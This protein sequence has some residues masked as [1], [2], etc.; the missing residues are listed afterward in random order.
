VITSR[1][2]VILY[3]YKNVA[4]SLIVRFR[5]R[6]ENVRCDVFSA[7]RA[8]LKITKPAVA[9]LNEARITG[10]PPSPEAAAAV[11]ALEAQIP[12]LV[13]TSYSQLAGSAPSNSNFTFTDQDCPET[14]QGEEYQESAGCT[15]ATSRASRGPSGL[16]LSLLAEH[17][18][19]D[20]H[21]LIVSTRV[22]KN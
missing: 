10:L 19:W 18:E 13:S 7:Y 11:Q 15:A 20:S 16:S 1:P 4:L 8:L 5:E 17:D 21:L 22:T 2:D 14:T 9:A 12:Q 6:E 3:V